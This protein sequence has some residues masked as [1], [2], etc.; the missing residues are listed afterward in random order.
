MTLFTYCLIFPQ[1]IFI[2]VFPHMKCE[3]GYFILDHNFYPT[4]QL[5]NF[6]D[7]QWFFIFLLIFMEDISFICWLKFLI[8]QQLLSKIFN[9]ANNEL[10]MLDCFTFYCFILL[11]Y[12]WLDWNVCS[13]NS[14]QKFAN[15]CLFYMEF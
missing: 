5:S 9:K 2:L 3:F 15:E 8:Y 10:F 1:F 7:S 14:K 13:F 12:I 11:R 4:S 6:Q